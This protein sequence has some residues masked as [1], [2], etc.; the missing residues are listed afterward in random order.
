MTIGVHRCGHD[1]DGVGAEAGQSLA[2]IGDGVN[3][4]PALR[5]TDI[6]VAMGQRGTEW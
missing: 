6:G 1:A 3:D 4:G 2:M 5:Q